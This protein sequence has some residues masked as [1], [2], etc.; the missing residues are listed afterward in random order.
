MRKEVPRD[1]AATP[2][3]RP[4]VKPPSP[5]KGLKR[6]APVAGKTEVKK[7]KP[8]VK[9]S[10]V[11]ASQAGT[12]ELTKAKKKSLKPK[13][14]LTKLSPGPLPQV[15]LKPVKE[16]KKESS[17]KPV[18]LKPKKVIVN[19]A[20]KK[21]IKLE[22]EQKKASTAKIVQAVKDLKNAKIVGDSKI[23]KELHK[24]LSNSTTTKKI[25]GGSINVVKKHNIV[26]RVNKMSGKKPCVVSVKISNAHSTVTLSV[27][28]NKQVNKKDS[29]KGM[30]SGSGK[31]PDRNTISIVKKGIAS[32]RKSSSKECSFQDSSPSNSP[33]RGNSPV[34]VKEE[35]SSSQMKKSDGGKTQK[36]VTKQS[37]IE[38]NKSS[39]EK[40]KDKSKTQDDSKNG[41]TEV[42]INDSVKI[43]TENV[44]EDQ[45]ME[46]EFTNDSIKDQGSDRGNDGKDKCKSEGSLLDF[47]SKSSS[48]E[49]SNLKSIDSSTSDEMP[50]E[51]LKCKQKIKQEK[52]SYNK[53]YEL[54]NYAK[55]KKEKDS[56]KSESLE[57]KKKSCNSKQA[58][59]NKK[60][61]TK[62]QP[63]NKV[64]ERMSKAALRKL[65]QESVAKLKSASKKKNIA[66]KQKI[67]KLVKNSRLNEQK[68]GKTQ[69]REDSSKSSDS[70]N[71]GRKRKKLMKFW[72][73]P[74]RHR[75]A[76][77]NAIAK[78]HC[79]YENESRG[80]FEMMS[81]AAALQRAIQESKKMAGIVDTKNKPK[82][83]DN[84]DKKSVC[85]KLTAK[86][87]R[88]A[89]PIVVRNLRT[90]PGVR[91]VGRNFDILNVISSTSLSS[92]SSEESSDSGQA[93]KQLVLLPTLKQKQQRIK[94]EESEQTSDED[95]CKKLPNA[96]VDSKDGIKKIKK[97]RRKRNELTM[98]LKDMVV[99]K[100]MA[101][102]NA[103][104]IMTATYSSEKKM[105]NNKLE[106]KKDEE[107]TIKKE[108][109][110]KKKQASNP[111][112]VD[113]SSG[114]EED[115]I[116]RTT[117]N[118]QKVA[119]IV[120]QDTDVTITG[121]YVNS[122][123]RSTRHEGYCSIAGMQYRISSTSHTQTEA[124]AVATETVLHTDHVSIPY[125]HLVT[126]TK[127][128]NSLLSWLISG[129]KVTYIIVLYIKK[130]LTILSKIVP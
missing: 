27:K 6:A 91:S 123:T 43:K 81:S 36:K 4:A 34:R 52:D 23:K 69:D 87:K 102:L 113:D 108:R 111:R 28:Q 68:H 55:I 10:D 117:K 101:S 67:A 63:K 31:S 24:K 41:K 47:K 121:V 45:N 66:L 21:V 65:D 97:R 128:L 53:S 116:L 39:D 9:Q 26:K 77:L 46:I 82:K 93:K 14:V 124:T 104:A 78:V 130:E 118:K 94:K 79:L 70:E 107:F 49:Y 37:L 15:K 106:K 125:S 44:G 96:H 38:S 7:K 112:D 95:V 51:I 20:T 57:N 33:T 35:K 100:R 12:A 29:T 18:K 54:P 19:K 8:T 3:P 11:G 127:I 62:K 22:N 60:S 90:N 50:L 30:K 98:D 56:F 115:V 120:N 84:K 80:A 129:N 109:K 32:R 5:G 71:S 103:S 73:G 85:K 40:S 86:E 48:N 105:E 89:E 1:S 92:S 126:D 25:P 42:F 58:S 110:K 88:L 74:K 122:T 2:K 119:V 99:R 17:P 75:V 64:P 114:E 61:E 13:V 83:P 76:S 72:N 59:E 16:V